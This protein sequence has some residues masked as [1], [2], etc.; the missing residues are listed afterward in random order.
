MTGLAETNVWRRRAGWATIVL[1]VAVVALGAMRIEYRV[2]LLEAKTSIT[3]GMSLRQATDAWGSAPV[4]L[5]RLQVHA[6]D[7]PPGLRTAQSGRIVRFSG[8]WP[9]S[10]MWVHVNSDDIVDVVI[11]KES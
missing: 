9:S 4:P 11:F 3:P 5:D 10:Y 6:S 2:R 7:L 1:G 8:A